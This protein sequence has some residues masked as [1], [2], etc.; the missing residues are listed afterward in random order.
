MITKKIKG[1]ARAIRARLDVILFSLALVVFV[2][3]MFLTINALVGGISL[4]IALAVAGYGVVLI[5][6]GTNTNRKE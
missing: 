5:D 3:T 6:N 1:L 4:T 2:L